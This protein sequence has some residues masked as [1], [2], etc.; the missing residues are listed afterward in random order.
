MWRFPYLVYLWGGG[1]FLIPFFF[2]LAVIGI[3]IFLLETAIGQFSGLSPRAIFGHISPLF[4]G[5]GYAAIIINSIIGFF[6]NVLIV[7]IVHFFIMSIREKL[8][9]ADCSYF[10][11]NVCFQIKNATAT[12]TCK[13]EKELFAMQNNGIETIISLYLLIK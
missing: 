10:D 7:Y 5:L 2:L 3:P 1:P 8:K 6:Y 9:W 13:Q 4:Q 11:S 12:E